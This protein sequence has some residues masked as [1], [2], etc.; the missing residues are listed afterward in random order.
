VDD[1]ALRSRKKL[2]KHPGTERLSDTVL[3]HLRRQ[4]TAPPETVSR[5]VSVLR[6]L[7]RL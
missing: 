3:G 4:Q 2:A 7:F 5:T 6:F 1:A